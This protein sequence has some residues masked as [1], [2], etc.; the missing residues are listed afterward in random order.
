MLLLLLISREE[1]CRRRDGALKR[2]IVCQEVYF[3]Q[4]QPPN[5]GGHSVEREKYKKVSTWAADKMSLKLKYL[6]LAGR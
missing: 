2:K 4:N 3:H 6:I 5:E 1:L